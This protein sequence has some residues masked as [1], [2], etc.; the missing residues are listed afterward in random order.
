MPF[1]LSGKPIDINVEYLKN[2]LDLAS[3]ELEV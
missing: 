3:I 1:L 2:I